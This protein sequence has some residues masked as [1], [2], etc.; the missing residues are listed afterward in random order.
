MAS[1]LEEHIRTDPISLA[2]CI[3][4]NQVLMIMTKF[5][6]LVPCESQSA[7]RA[8]KSNPQAISISTGG[9]T[10]A[11]YSPYLA[12]KACEFPD[13]KIAIDAVPAW[14][15]SATPHYCGEVSTE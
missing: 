11:V 3:N 7:L 10:A 13:S 9:V 1:Y 14:T 12:R 6:T 4:T 8:A 5:G 15:A 2:P